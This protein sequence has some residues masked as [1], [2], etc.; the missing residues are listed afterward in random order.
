MLKLNRTTEYG[1]FALRHLSLKAP[2]A[3]ASAREIAAHYSLPFDITA[4]TLQR[5]KEAGLITSAQGSRGGYTLQRPL[6]Q[7]NLAEFLELME[8]PQAVVVCADGSVAQS[9]TEAS[10]D[11]SAC[12][13]SDRCQI[14]GVLK[15]LD[16]RIKSVLATVKLS[17]FAA[18]PVVQIQSIQTLPL[19]AAGVRT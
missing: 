4:K 18:Q 12:E 10:H 11:R 19:A 2:G 1:I 16:F 6:E 7:V 8:G 14:S 3:S 9:A 13:Y 15:N 17:E 5:L